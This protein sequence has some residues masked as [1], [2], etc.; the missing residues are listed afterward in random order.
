MLGGRDEIVWELQ[1]LQAGK[2]SYV[3]CYCSLP[4]AGLLLAGWRLARLEGRNA[5]G[6]FLQNPK[7]TYM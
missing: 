5:I 4:I 6:N 1:V 3:L 7:D 2:V